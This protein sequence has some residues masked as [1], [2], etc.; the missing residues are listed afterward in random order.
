MSYLAE[1][2][3]DAKRLERKESFRE[4]YRLLIH[5]AR[6]LLPAWRREPP[7]LPRSMC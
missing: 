6:H 4:L 5:P 3:F 7:G 1:Q 2:S